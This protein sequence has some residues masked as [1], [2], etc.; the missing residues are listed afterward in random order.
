MQI[1]VS[2]ESQM[3]LYAWNEAFLRWKELKMCRFLNIKN[4]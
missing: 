4:R 2:L 3:K 1:L